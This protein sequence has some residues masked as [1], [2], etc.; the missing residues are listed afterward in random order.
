VENDLIE[1]GRHDLIFPTF[2]INRL[3]PGVGG[4]ILAALLAA[5]MSSIDSGINSIATVLSA[6]ASRGKARKNSSRVRF[7]MKITCGAGLFITVAAYGLSF[8]PDKWGIVAA[9]PRTFNAVTGP[10]GGLFMIGMFFPRAGQRAAIAGVCCGLFTSVSIGYSEQIG[11]LL[12]KDW[13]ALSFTWV[14]PCSISVTLLV[15]WLVGLTGKPPTRDLAGLTWKTR[16]API[17]DDKSSE[18]TKI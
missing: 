3:P 12:S 5:A 15:A 2:A 9:L 14:M 16:H 11:N 4:G 17:V 10:L 18:S 8:L 7:A 1:K 13:P 6:E